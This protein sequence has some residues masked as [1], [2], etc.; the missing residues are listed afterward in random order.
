MIIGI[1]TCVVQDVWGASATGPLLISEMGRAMGY[2]VGYTQVEG[3]HM[4]DRYK[5]IGN[6]FHDGVMGHILAC[7]ISDM[8]M[9]GVVTRDDVRRQEV[10]FTENKDHVE[11][12]GV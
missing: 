11:P 1:V 9:S 6:A 4:R 8:T 3:L 7:C 12:E 10:P 5:V 2:D